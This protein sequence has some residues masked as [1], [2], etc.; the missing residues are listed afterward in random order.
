M[1]SDPSKSVDAGGCEVASALGQ[2]PAK[3]VVFMNRL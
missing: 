3:V 1:S 2:T